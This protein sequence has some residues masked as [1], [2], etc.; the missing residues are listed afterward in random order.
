MILSIWNDGDHDSDDHVHRLLIKPGE[1]HMF[2]V[3]RRP[4][5]RLVTLIMAIGALAALALPAASA[6]TSRPASPSSTSSTAS[7]TSSTA[8]ASHTKCV[9]TGV[10]T[11]CTGTASGNNA[12]NPWAATNFTSPDKGIWPQISHPPVVTVS[13]TKDLTDQVVNVSWQYFTPSL[14][15]TGSPDQGTNSQNYEVTVYECEGTNPTWDSNG[16]G[17]FPDPNSCY[18]SNEGSQGLGPLG[19]ALT[20]GQGSAGITI[21]PQACGIPESWAQSGGCTNGGNPATW[22]GSAQFHIETK[23]TNSS[24]GCDVNTPCSLVIVPNFGGNYSEPDG[25]RENGPDGTGGCENHY[26]DSLE[27][28]PEGQN[29]ASVIDGACSYMDRIVVPLS[30]A[31]TPSNCPAN[32]IQDPEFQA[33]GSPMMAQQMTQWQTAWCTSPAGSLTFSS[34]PEEQARNA[35]LGGGQALGNGVDMALTTLPALGVSSSSRKFTYA[36]LANSG[37][38]IA[39]YVDDGAPANTNPVTG[40]P[41]PSPEVGQQIN[42][43]VLN[44]RLVAKLTTESYALNYSCA[45]GPVKSSS[46]CDPA[47]AGNTQNIFQDPEFLSLNKDCQP[48]FAPANYQCGAADFQ[49]ATNTLNFGLFMPTVLSAQSDITYQ[50]TDWVAA[51]ADAQ[52][53]LA[54]KSAQGMHIN[55]YYKNATSYP[56]EQFSALDPGWTNTTPIKCS[57]TGC[58]NPAVP[59]ATMQVAWNFVATQEQ[60]AQNLLGF[61]PNADYTI[62]VCQ[63]PSGTCTSPNQYG[64]VDLTGAGTNNSVGEGNLDLLSEMDLGDVGTYQFPAAALV[65]ADGQAVT[66]TQASVEHTVAK[67]M[68]TNPDGITQYVDQS[69][70]DPGVYPLT[71]VDY[72]MVP[73]CGLKPAQATAIADF[74][75]NVATTG[76]KQGVLPGQMQPGYYPL[77][78]AQLA[79]TVKAAQE[80]RTQDCKSA[81]SDPGSANDGGSPADS[82]SPAKTPASDHRTPSTGSTPIGHDRTAAFGQKSADSGLAGILLVLAMVFGVLLVVGGPTAWVITVTGRWPVVLGQVRAVRARSLTGLGRLAARVVRRA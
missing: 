25:Y 68:E 82:S 77:T 53:F 43:L 26:N 18:E 66:P 67:D 62:P 64:F 29:N 78:S 23:V 22:E 13:Q 70:K 40:A 35:F 60:I 75:D 9:T 48:T 46:S 2:A 72:A 17:T 38:A 6:A 3:R 81:P 69:S 36:P 24:L 65:N 4:A 51:N 33:E 10:S 73:T 49:N 80:V 27:I 76:Q 12:Y 32:V 47:V 56:T 11:T 7:S 30:F 15:D 20:A 19:D 52:A 41:E 58:A 31:P 16:L 21:A 45:S 61:K 54:G 1:P 63:D 44:P 59:Y 79:Q 5:V 39:Y 55:K 42:R 34:V 14:D 50:L 37:A 28:E 74:L 71:M 57:S 8:P